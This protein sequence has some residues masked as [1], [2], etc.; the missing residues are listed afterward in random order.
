MSEDPIAAA[1]KSWYGY[2]RW[3]ASYW[4]IG[5]EPGM[6][7]DEGEELLARCRAWEQIGSIELIHC[8][9]H[10]RSFGYLKWLLDL[11]G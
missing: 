3:D 11:F 10:H 4:L 5:P 1:T 9:A 8:F 7:K 2:G 6:R